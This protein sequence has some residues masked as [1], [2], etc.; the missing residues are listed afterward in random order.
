MDNLQPIVIKHRYTGEVL[1]GGRHKLISEAVAA[2]LRSDASLSG[3]DLTGANLYEADLSGADLSGANLT[4]ANLTETSLIRASL[5]GAD[6]SGADL[7]RTDL[8]GANL[9]GANLYEADLAGAYL[10][11]IKKDLFDVLSHAR[12]E[13]GFLLAELE[14]GRINGTMYD[15][16]CC[17]LVGTIAKCRGC[18]YTKLDGIQPDSHRPIERWFYAIY[19]GDTP[20]NSQIA[21]ITAGWIREFLEAANV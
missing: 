17:C 9:S 13:A 2:A 4:G 1:Y 5:S 14:A 3:A 8:T 10:S 20:E 19:P 16:A 6:L 12:N 11:E 18:H 7:I 21:K 15:S